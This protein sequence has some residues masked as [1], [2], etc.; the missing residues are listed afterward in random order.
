M[1]LDEKVYQQYVSFAKLNL[2]QKELAF[3][4]VHDII[5][6]HGD[7]VNLLNFRGFILN[8]IKR[9]NSFIKHVSL[10]S[11][12]K[13]ADSI[14]IFCARCKDILPESEFK[15]TIS[16]SGQI[17]IEFCCNKC[18]VKYRKEY[19]LKNK[20]KLSLQARERYKL[21]KKV[22][23]DYSKE[24]RSKNKEKVKAYNKKY[25]TKNKAKKAELDKQY[26]EKN[27]EKLKIY[28]KEYYQRNKNKWV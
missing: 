12:G 24:Y 7:K 27:K 25:R 3:D 21:N 11:I 8:Y 18:M 26:Q 5:L 22:M 28:N 2:K 14:D 16:S 23:D 10:E 6:E 4:I 9:N 15:K 19:Y 20:E 1:E 13:K 17:K